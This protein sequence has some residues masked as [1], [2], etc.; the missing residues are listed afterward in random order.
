MFAIV[1]GAAVLI[2]AVSIAVFTT[3]YLRGD[4]SGLPPELTERREALLERLAAVVEAVPETP[5][6]LSPQL[7]AHPRTAAVEAKLL[8]QNPRGALAEA[9]GVLAESPGE[10]RAHLLLARALIYADE[11]EGA[12]QQLRRAAELGD[13]SPMLRFLEARTEHLRQLREV[14]TDN[15]EINESP[16]PSMVTPL[17]VLILSLERQRKLADSG[18]GVWIPGHGEIG[19]D[20][21]TAMVTE[22]FDRYYAT[23]EKLL[24]A[25]EELPGFASALYHLARMALKIGAVELGRK[26]FEAIEPLMDSSPDKPYFERDIAQLR[27]ETSSLVSPLPKLTGTAKRSDKLKVL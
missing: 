8:A 26:L 16:L 20:E 18:S 1:I 17:E 14:H 15:A 6:L 24:D 11:L 7:P 19:D 3:W 22:H 23:T 27:E 12:E 2:I 4:R 13:Q 10:A 21:I 5:A 25:V 9:E